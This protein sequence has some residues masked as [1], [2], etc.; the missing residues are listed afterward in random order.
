VLLSVTKYPYYYK[1]SFANS[2][3]DLKWL[4]NMY[5]GPQILDKY[6]QKIVWTYRTGPIHVNRTVD[7]PLSELHLMKL[8]QIL[9]SVLPEDEDG[10]SPRNVVFKRID[11]ALRPRKLY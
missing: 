1:N 10:A 8:H 6:S 2:L 3:Y 9:K 5:T 4:D 11:A 7:W